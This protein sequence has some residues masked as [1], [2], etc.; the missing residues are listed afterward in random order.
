MITKVRPDKQKSES[1][2]KMAEVT[3]ERLEN[4]DIVKYP[5]Q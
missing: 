2:K 3:L 4:T 1:L 5:L